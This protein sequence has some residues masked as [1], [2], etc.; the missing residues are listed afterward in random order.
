ML[1]VILWSEDSFVCSR[2]VDQAGQCPIE[3]S[4]PF[5][6]GR[7]LPPG[8]LRQL[9]LEYHGLLWGATAFLATIIFYLG[10]CRNICI[11]K[12]WTASRFFHSLVKQRYRRDE[13]GIYI[14][15]LLKQGIISTLAPLTSLLPRKQM[16]STYTG[17]RGQSSDHSSSTVH[18]SRTSV[19]TE[20]RKASWSLI[21][22]NHASTL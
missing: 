13:R 7:P 2:A 6:P 20:A 21:D 3:Q 19:L 16:Q 22:G 12:T 15:G 9:V 17:S 1:V 14:R 5:R 4:V 8:L 11:R 18:Q 10:P